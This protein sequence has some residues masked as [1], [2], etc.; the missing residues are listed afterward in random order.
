MNNVVIKGNKGI[1][2]IA[3]DEEMMYKK[4]DMEYNMELI[5]QFKKL[6]DKEEITK[7]KKS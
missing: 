4:I 6:K 1:T 2:N 5:D 7:M 3:M